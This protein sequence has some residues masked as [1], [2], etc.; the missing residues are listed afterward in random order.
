MRLDVTVIT[1][2]FY[3]DNF[4]TVEKCDRDPHAALISFMQFT[5]M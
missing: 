5:Q 4:M 2:T 3:L 1:V